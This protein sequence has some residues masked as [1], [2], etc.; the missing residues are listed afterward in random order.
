MKVLLLLLFQYDSYEFKKRKPTTKTTKF[1][2]HSCFFPI[3]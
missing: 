2:L 3:L 1:L